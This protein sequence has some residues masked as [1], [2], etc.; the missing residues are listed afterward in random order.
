[1]EYPRG[2]GGEGRPAG[3]RFFA[4]LRMTGGGVPP[5]LQNESPAERVSF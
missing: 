5:A 3:V 1:M 2:C 4:L